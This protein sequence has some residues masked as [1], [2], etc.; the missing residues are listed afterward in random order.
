MSEFGPISLKPLSVLL[1]SL[2]TTNVFSFISASFS[3]IPKK[4]EARLHSSLEET[5]KMCQSKEKAL[6]QKRQE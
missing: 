4:R 6:G 5:A 1:G 2:V 3:C